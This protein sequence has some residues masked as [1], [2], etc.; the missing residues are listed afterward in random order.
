MGEYGHMWAQF[1]MSSANPSYFFLILNKIRKRYRTHIT[2]IY[3][4]YQIHSLYKQ[5]KNSRLTS[6]LPKEKLMNKGKNVF[7]CDYYR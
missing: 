6:N 1:K 4:N 3:A 2:T 7:N 5:V